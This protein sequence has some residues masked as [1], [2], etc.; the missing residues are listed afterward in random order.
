ME[1]GV[2]GWW[3]GDDVVE[4]PYCR[5]NE[6]A[7]SVAMDDNVEHANYI[8]HRRFKVA[9][10]VCYFVD[11]N[12]D[13]RDLIGGSNV[14]SAKETGHKIPLARKGCARPK[15]AKEGD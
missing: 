9:V 5:R 15:A 14:Y 13:R 3:V 4:V 12:L 1:V 6:G 10:K 11:L 7:K 8:Q 2:G